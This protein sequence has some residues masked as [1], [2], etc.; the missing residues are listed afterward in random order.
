MKKKAT[1]TKLTGL[2][3]QSNPCACCPSIPA[4]LPLTRRIAVG[5][6]AALLTKDGEVEWSEG[7]NVA[8]DQ[9]L[10][11]RQAENRAVKDPTHDWRIILNGPLHGETYQRHGPKQWVLVEKNGGFV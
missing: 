2:P 1:W 4:T 8:Y 5:F 7:P 10:S 6:G 9:C 3:R 11:V